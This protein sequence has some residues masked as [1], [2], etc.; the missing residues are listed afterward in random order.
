MVEYTDEEIVAMVKVA[1]DYGT[2]V[3]AH[4]HKGPA[5]VRAVKNGVRCIEHGSV[6]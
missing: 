3:M 2:Y 5:I 6:L 4:S 1:E